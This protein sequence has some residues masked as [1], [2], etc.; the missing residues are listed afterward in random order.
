MWN[1]ADARVKGAGSVGAVC[2]QGQK[3]RQGPLE[4][5]KVCQTW[6]PHYVEGHLRR[7]KSPEAT[8]GSIYCLC[9]LTV[10]QFPHKGSLKMG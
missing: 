9:C 1:V 8:E 6:G 2:V 4:T 7:V 3:L 5:P 10:P